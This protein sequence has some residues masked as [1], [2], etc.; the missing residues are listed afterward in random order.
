[1]YSPLRSE[2]TEQMYSLHR[3]VY[4]IF[5]QTAQYLHTPQYFY[6]PVNWLSS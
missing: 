4:S 6:T 5:R 2:D 1:V 3:R